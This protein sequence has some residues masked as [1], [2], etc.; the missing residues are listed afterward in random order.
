VTPGICFV[1][2]HIIS[3]QA[4]LEAGLEALRLFRLPNPHV[5]P[6]REEQM[7]AV[8]YREKRDIE[9]L[10]LRHGS[11]CTPSDCYHGFF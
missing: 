9:T 1:F 8:L 7:E 11:G 4:T 3:Y 6:Q 2:K 5:N 10:Q